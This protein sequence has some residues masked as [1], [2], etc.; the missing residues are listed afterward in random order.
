[1][2]V[3]GEFKPCKKY[4]LCNIA[5]KLFNW[6]SFPANVISYNILNY[7]MQEDLATQNRAISKN[8]D[9]R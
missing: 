2:V 8:S 4:F 3:L 7:F 1:M 9:F 6:F 5:H